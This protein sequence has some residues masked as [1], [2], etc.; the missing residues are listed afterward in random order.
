MKSVGE[1]RA[2]VQ[3]EDA[4]FGCDGGDHGSPQAPS[5]WLFGI[6][7]G[8]GKADA[9][10]DVA[11]PEEDRSAEYQ[12]YPIG[13]QLGWP[14]NRN[15]FKLLA[16]IDNI[17]PASYRA[18]ANDRHPFESGYK[19]YFKGNLSP[20]PFNKISDWDGGARAVTGFDERRSYES[21]LRVERLPIIA[22][23]VAK[24]RPKL[25]IGVGTSRRDDF[26]AAVGVSELK[27]HEFDVNGSKKRIWWSKGQRANM[28]V[29]PHLSGGPNGLNSNVSIRIA[30]EFIRE[31]ILND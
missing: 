2:L 26:S 19:G 24:Y 30:G 8:W 29:I 16:A 21:W 18:F 3:D 28:V 4:F 17:D 20:I 11:Q 23:W 22:E 14:F 25:F 27:L 10:S 31:K 9:E 12:T 13:L 7:P 6:E 15:A 1:F 5:I